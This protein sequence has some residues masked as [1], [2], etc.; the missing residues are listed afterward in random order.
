M[1]ENL[2]TLS[3]VLDKLCTILQID[4]VS[5]KAIGG[6]NRETSH[7]H[8]YQ[9]LIL[10]YFHLKYFIRKR[11]ILENAITLVKLLLL[12]TRHTRPFHITFIF[13]LPRIIFSSLI[14]NNQN[15]FELE[16]RFVFDSF[17]NCVCSVLFLFTGCIRYIFASLFCM[18]KRQH[19]RNKEKCF[20][21]HFKSS[22][23]S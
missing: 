17:L 6:K 11:Q 7:K 12:A 10:P 23:C 2:A 1:L 5:L 21:F 13:S 19:L 4:L 14:M 15:S 16:F 9:L 3:N 18:S 8:Y 22:S 20:L